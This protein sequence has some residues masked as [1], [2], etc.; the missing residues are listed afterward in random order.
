MNSMLEHVPTEEQRQVLNECLRCRGLIV[1]SYA[2][3]EFLLADLCIKSWRLPSYRSLAKRFPYK[4]ETRERAVSAILALEAGPLFEFRAAAAPLLK[5]WR[6]SERDRNI[7]AHGLVTIEWTKGDNV[8]VRGQ[9]LKPIDDEKF[10]L[11][12]VKWSLSTLQ[13]KAGRATKCSQ[14]WMR[15][16]YAMHSKMSWIRSDGVPV[17]LFKDD[18]S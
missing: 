13:A 4:S 10:G 5:E 9:L 14:G 8:F 11:E 1:G 16:C 12:R 6:D 7:M 17:G 15:V 3:V 18:S 2:H